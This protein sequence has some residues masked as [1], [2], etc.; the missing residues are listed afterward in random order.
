M[1]G[2]NLLQKALFGLSVKYIKYLALYIYG[3]GNM[4]SMFQKQQEDQCE[5]N[6]IRRNIA[7]DRTFDGA[8]SCMNF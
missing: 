2:G 8:G 5:E 7:K 1:I 3:G 4:L 6:V